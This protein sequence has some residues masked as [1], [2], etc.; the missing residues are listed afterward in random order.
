LQKYQKGRVDE[1]FLCELGRP[2]ELEVTQRT[3][4]IPAVGDINRDP[5]AEYRTLQE[6]MSDNYERVYLGQ[7]PHVIVADL[8]GCDFGCITLPNTTYLLEQDRAKQIYACIL[9]Y[10][11]TMKALAYRKIDYM[12]LPSDVSKQY[13]K[14]ALDIINCLK[15]AVTLI[16]LS[17]SGGCFYPTTHW[18]LVTTMFVEMNQFKWQMQNYIKDHDS[19]DLKSVIEQITAALADQNADDD[20]D[21]RM[22]MTLAQQD[23]LASALSWFFK[24]TDDPNPYLRRFFDCTEVMVNFHTK[25]GKAWRDAKRQ[26]AFMSKLL[27]RNPRAN[28]RHELQTKASSGNVAVEMD[29]EVFNSVLKMINGEEMQL[30]DL[31]VPVSDVLKAANQMS[32]DLAQ[33]VEMERKRR[34]EDEDVTEPSDSDD[35]P[36]AQQS[37]T[38]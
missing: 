11:R 10:E 28:L 3:D 21:I 6:T 19:L 24:V 1:E 29:K 18:L 5:L 30:T 8:L 27:K 9:T 26:A 15:T 34:R 23:G 33:T 17:I 31:E 13:D 14:A 12:R 38:E 7:F 32:V 20:P 25:S 2:F 22:A 4:V 35:E 36:K 37:R 16:S